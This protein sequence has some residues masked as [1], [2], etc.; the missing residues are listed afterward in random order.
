MGL[1]T[2]RSQFWSSRSISSKYEEESEKA[3]G[4]RLGQLLG[5][6]PLG[7]GA[8]GRCG[9]ALASHLLSDTYTERVNTSRNALPTDFR[10][11][12]VC[13]LHAQNP[14]CGCGAS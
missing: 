11:D 12:L 9:G 7:V 1:L 8:L 4:Q 10:Y 6:V 3:G 2:G 14:A 13:N 5:R